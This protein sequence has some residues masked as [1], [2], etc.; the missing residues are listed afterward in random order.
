MEASTAHP[1]GITLG[2]VCPMANEQD[3]AAQFVA[4]VLAQCR[5]EGFKSVTFFA[6]L[7]RKSVDQT[8]HILDELAMRESDLRVIWAP[9]NKCVV[10]AY[11][12][13]YREALNA[14]SDWILEIDAGFSHQPADISQFFTRMSQGY[15]CVFGSRFVPGGSIKDSSFR[16]YLISRGGTILSN[17]LLGTSLKDMTSGFELFSRATVQYLLDK[18]IRSHGSFFQTEIKAYCRHLKIAEV[19][20]RYRG[21]SHHVGGAELKD[22]F[23]S[24]WRLFQLRVQGQL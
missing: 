13:G 24:L 22:S 1:S 23:S 5:R 20:I 11:V 8:R 19:P 9:Q 10:D 15:D 4:E 3:C 6:I 7:D 18:G 16:R 2:I 12:V 17:V 21:A 14:G